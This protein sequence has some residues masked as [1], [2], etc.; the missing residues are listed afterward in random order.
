VP[1]PIVKKAKKRTPDGVIYMGSTDPAMDEAL[2]ALEEHGI[3][4]DALRIR[5]FPFCNEVFEFIRNHEQ[6]FIV[7]Q[8]RDGQLKALL[9]NE[10]G[11]HPAR[12]VSVRHYDGSPIS[13]RFII[14]DITEKLKG[15]HAAALRENAQ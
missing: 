5:A 6:V 12:L 1:G 11:V 13:A 4:L 3:H 9:V 2:C 8:N 10:G 15:P 14:K 7:E